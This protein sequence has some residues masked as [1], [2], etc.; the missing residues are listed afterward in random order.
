MSD[1]AAEPTGSL[2]TALA[3]TASMLGDRPALAVLQAQEILRVVP[4]HPQAQ[5]LLGVAHRL[6]GDPAAARAVLAP[7]A[8]QAPAWSAPH[9][10]LG[11]AE[12]ALGETDAAIEGLRRAVAIDP[13]QPHAWRALG[14]LLLVRGEVEAAQEAH[15]QVVNASVGDPVLMQ[16][17]SALFENRLDVA[18]RLIRPFLQAHPTDVA[19]IRMLAEVAARLGRFEDAEHLL[20]RC[21]ALAPGFDAA[22]QNYATVLHRQNKAVEAL[23]EIERLLEKDP[24]NAGLLS[25]KAASVSRTGDQDLSAELYRAVLE[26]HPDQPK[27]WMSYGHTLKAIGRT[28]E[29]VEAYRRST[30]LAP[31]FGEAWWSLANLKT[32]RFEAADI[33]AMETG[34]EAD[35]LGPE[36][37]FHLHFALGKALEDEGRWEAA[38][39]HYARGAALRRE[40]L[41]YEPEETTEQL[42]RARAFFTPALFKAREGQGN[43]APD[44]IFVVGLPR[45][46]STLV[47]QILSS[48]SQVEGTTELPDIALLARRV[49]GRDGKGGPSAYPEVL[50]SLSAT[51]LSDLGQAYLDATRVH[52][53]LG[54]PLFI[55]KMPNNFLHAGFIAL[56]LPRA[57]IVDVRRHPLACCFSG[58]KQH[59]ARGQ[60]FSYDLGDIGRW[61][62]DYVALMDHFDAAAPGRVHRVI[63]E[64]LVADPEA[65][66]RALLAHCGLA[67]EESTLR[68]WETERIVR[69]ASSEQ[70]RR[71]IY[72]EGLDQWRHF[73]PWLDPLKL[74]LGSSLERW[75]SA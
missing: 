46:G 29:A 22:R 30:A 16:A 57:K 70:V 60:A 2:E 40:G 35:S 38:F 72:T 27:V 25:L 66:V 19:A 48:H 21:L 36:D 67:F 33:A 12:A 1:S 73:E 54:R 44:P 58:F 52:R 31:T 47:E 42:E 59:F 17:A 62:R 53:K 14:D 34:L 6:N 49:G 65:Q 75:R 61:Y 26:R 39:G 20:E 32:V 43:P 71:P 64:D 24:S 11:L 5:L 7:L 45:S 18:E 8:A 23:V 63:Y 9:V 4:G 37:A 50:A 51:E 3:H 41:A 74:A 56:I 28:A 10:E 55:D 69:T 15:G 13:M 68:F